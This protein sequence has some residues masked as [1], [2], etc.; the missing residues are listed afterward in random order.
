[1]FGSTSVL[2]YAELSERVGTAAL[3]IHI[4]KQV[5]ENV[6]K[7]NY[8]LPCDTTNGNTS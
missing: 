5:Q 8:T 2:I 7:Y 6:S 1:M 4:S 3:C